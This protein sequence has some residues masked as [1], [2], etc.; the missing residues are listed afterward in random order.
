MGTDVYIV[1]VALGTLAAFAIDSN[2]GADCDLG[3]S[4][5]VVVS[6]A[7]FRAFSALELRAIF[8]IVWVVRGGRVK[9]ADLGIMALT[10]EDIADARNA[11]LSLTGLDD[12]GKAG[13][14]NFGNCGVQFDTGTGDCTTWG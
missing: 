7:D 8:A 13:L 2:A 3:T 1:E 11:V 6:L 12:E 5:L 10:L 9:F 4:S 14:S